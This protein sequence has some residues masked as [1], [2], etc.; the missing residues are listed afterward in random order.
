MIHNE[1]LLVF[2]DTHGNTVIGDGW[3]VLVLVL[4]LEVG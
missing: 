2:F 3:W 4:V 1:T